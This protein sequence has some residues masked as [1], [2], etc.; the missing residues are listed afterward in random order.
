MILISEGDFLDKNLY[1]YKDAKDLIKL[2][3]I[4]EEKGELNFFQHKILEYLR[5]KYGLKHI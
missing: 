2:S 5:K 3:E 1:E 4:I